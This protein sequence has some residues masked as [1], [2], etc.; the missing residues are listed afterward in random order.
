VRSH[1]PSHVTRRSQ[2]WCHDCFDDALVDRILAREAFLFRTLS[3]RGIDYTFENADFDQPRRKDVRLS[4]AGGDSSAS[5]KCG[6]S[7]S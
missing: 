2:P 7:P 5:R 1:P 3:R 6:D 4:L